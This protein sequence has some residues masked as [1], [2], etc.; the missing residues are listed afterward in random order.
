MKTLTCNDAVVVSIV[1][2]TDLVVKSAAE[3]VRKTEATASEATTI[4][5]H[6]IR[7]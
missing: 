4:P 3:Q 2:T 7:P 5:S 6:T 1:V